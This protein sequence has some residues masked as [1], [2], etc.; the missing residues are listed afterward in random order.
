MY[1]LC[2]QCRSRSVGFWR[3]QLIWVCTVEEA[4][5]S[6]SALFAI[7]YVNLYLDQIIWLDKIKN[8]RGILIYSA[9]QWLNSNIKGNRRTFKRDNSV[10][11]GRPPFRK[12]VYS[13]KKA[14]APLGSKFFP[15]RIHS[16][17]ERTWCAEKEKRRTQKLSIL[18]KHGGNPI[19]SLVP[20]IRILVSKSIP[21]D[22]RQH[23]FRNRRSC[24]TE[25]V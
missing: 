20:L 3:S 11:T 15:F 4:N 22:C 8:G 5:W 16:F 1:C 21:A 17:W 13:K 24:E 2:K 9:W 19:R 25:R 18:Q 14:F 10:K 7:K 23:C 6:G 12:G